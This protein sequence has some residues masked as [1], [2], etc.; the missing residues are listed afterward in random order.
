M[1]FSHQRKLIC[2]HHV[3]SRPTNI[4]SFNA[5]HVCP[6]RTSGNRSGG[7]G[8]GDKRVA[9]DVNRRQRVSSGGGC[10]AKESGNPAL[11]GSRKLARSE[12]HII[13]KENSTFARCNV[14]KYFY[15]K[16]SCHRVCAAGGW[17]V[18]KNSQTAKYHLVAG[19][20]SAI[21]KGP[22]QRHH[23]HCL[24]AIHRHVAVG[25]PVKKLIRKI[26]GKLDWRSRAA[27]LIG[28]DQ[29]RPVRQLLR[30]REAGIKREPAGILVPGGK[31][32]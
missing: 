10:G 7:G 5:K 24:A 19:Y 18:K 4:R 25:I 22:F 23:Q 28:R 32:V 17:N 6:E 12:P 9:A 1:H 29:T 2:F 27:K 21:E 3:D 13:R 15:A 11:Q 20:H 30:V 16:W 14:W 8:I 26:T 31:P